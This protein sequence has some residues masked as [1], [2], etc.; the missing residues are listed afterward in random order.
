MK[1]YIG[2]LLGCMLT[3]SAWSQQRNVIQNGRAVQK[4]TAVKANTGQRLSNPW[5]VGGGVGLSFG[6][7]SYMGFSI[8][9]F[10][11]YEL[12]PYTE[13]G[14]AA[15]YQ[16]SKDDYIKQNL[17]KVGPYVNVYPIPEIFGRVQYEYYTGSAKAKSN[18]GGEK[19]TFDENALWVG[20]GYRNTGPVQFYIGLM[21]N[22][23]YNH[24]S[25]IF[26][27]GFRPIAGVSFQI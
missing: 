18:Y 25:K 10:V 2:V 8:A 16:Y 6:D 9:P 1:K 3:I 27:N 14:I 20:A 12:N 19:Y 22:V 26:S 7:N 13:L 23:L 24:D 21:Y 5:R 11:G 4:P 15:G 17:F